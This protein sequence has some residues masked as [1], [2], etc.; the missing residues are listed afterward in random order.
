MLIIGIDAATWD[1]IKPNLDKLP[2]IK[3]LT[4]TGVHKTI[5]LDQKPWSP[6][7]WASMF[8]GLK[9]EEHG[10]HDFVENGNIVTRE[11]INVDFIWDLLDRKGISVKVLNV[12][13]IVPPYCF[14][15][16]FEPVANGVPIDVHELL[17][18]IEKVTQKGLEILR[19]DK[20][21]LFIMAYTALDKL[22][23]LHW[24]EP[25]MVE[26]YQ[27][28]DEKIGQLKE[29]DDQVILISDH[30][31]CNYD[32]APIQ[33]LP[34]K[35]PKGVIKGDHHPD[36]VYVGKNIEFEVNQPTDI[37]KGLEKKYLR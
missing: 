5:Q 26:Y 31:F 36:A 8:C 16:D 25:V 3:E 9:P 35:T 21:E 23:H 37:F 32:E 4:E 28:V 30:G 7:V 17:E 15:L 6:E 29:Y 13:F 12:P 33:T 2:N 18:E 20:P 24:G 27:K 1:V 22:S 14:N 11:D 34:K 10:H 19:N